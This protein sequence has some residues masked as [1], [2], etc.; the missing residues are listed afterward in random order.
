MSR[1][2][3]LLGKILKNKVLFLRYK[4]MGFEYILNPQTEELHHMNSDFLG[5]HN[6][7]ASDLENFIGIKNIGM[8]DI[9]KL[10]DGTPIPVYDLE[11]KILLGEYRLNKCQHC[12]W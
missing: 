11:T 7:H 10:E 5:S 6:L 1:D 9:N 2:F 8:L 3:I 4:K 12:S